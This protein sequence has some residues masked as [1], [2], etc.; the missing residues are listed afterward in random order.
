VSTA[1]L[2]GLTLGQLAALRSIPFERAR[3]LVEPFIAAGIIEDQDGVL[4][5]VDPFVASAFADWEVDP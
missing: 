4:V 3:L 2:T 1:T 5:V